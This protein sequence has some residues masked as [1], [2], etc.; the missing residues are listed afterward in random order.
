MQ[1]EQTRLKLHKD[2]SMPFIWTEFL[3]Q[4]KSNRAKTQKGVTS[5]KV[6]LHQV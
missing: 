1:T 4:L 5:I 3:Q 6:S 2:Y